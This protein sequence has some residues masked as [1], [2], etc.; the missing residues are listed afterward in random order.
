MLEDVAFRIARDGV[1][2]PVLHDGKPVWV[3]L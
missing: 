1:A 3:C 2:K